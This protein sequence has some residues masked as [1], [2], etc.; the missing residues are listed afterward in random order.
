MM[1]HDRCVIC[2]RFIHGPPWYALLCAACR[3]EGLDVVNGCPRCGRPR[4]G[5]FLCILCEESADRELRAVAD[6]SERQVRQRMYD[7][8][9]LAD[10]SRL[11]EDTRYPTIEEEWARYRRG[12]K[13]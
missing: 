7:L 3:L 4:T 13:P 5:M 1:K 9:T 12:E 6:G 11:L 8:A 10:W 2:K